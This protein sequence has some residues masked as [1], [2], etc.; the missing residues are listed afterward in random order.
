VFPVELPPPRKRLE[1]VPVLAEHFLAQSARRLGRT[2]P[3]PTLASRIKALGLSR[4]V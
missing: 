4:Q 3:R 2:K 1:D